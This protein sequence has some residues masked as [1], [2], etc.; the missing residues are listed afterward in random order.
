MRVHTLLHLNL[1][2][3]RISIL[4]YLMIFYYARLLS[5][6]PEQVKSFDQKLPFCPFDVP[7]SHLTRGKLLQKN[8]L[9]R[10]KQSTFG[11]AVNVHRKNEREN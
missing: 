11:Q 1:L 4:L 8:I 5:I 2:S 6:R 9:F 10:C 3:Y 7:F